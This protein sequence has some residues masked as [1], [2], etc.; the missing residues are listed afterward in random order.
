MAL[1][2]CLQCGQSFD[3]TKIEAIAIGRRYI[4]ATCKPAYDAAQDEK[5]AKEEAKAKEAEALNSLKAYIL[6]LFDTEYINPK[7]SKQIHDF[8]TVNHFTY[9]GMEKSLRYFFEVKNKPI[10]DAH[11]GIGIIPYIY[12][13]AKKYWYTVWAAKQLN[14]AKPIEQYVAPPEQVFKIKVPEP[15]LR[16]R[17]HLF[18]FLDE[19]EQ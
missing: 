2:K 14:E 5:K 18:T 9:S 4:H 12:E 19:E 16:T 7:I 1:V 6:Q 3:R 10:E 15:P 8:Y 17:K 13:D 11:G